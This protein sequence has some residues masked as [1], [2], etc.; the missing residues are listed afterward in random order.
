MNKPYI[1][2]LTPKLHQ[3][4]EVNKEAFENFPDIAKMFPEVYNTKLLK[5]T[6]IGMK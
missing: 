5:R 2:D 6:I 3:W 1:L 4:E